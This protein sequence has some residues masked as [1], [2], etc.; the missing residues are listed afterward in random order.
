MMLFSMAQKKKQTVVG[1]TGSLQSSFTGVKMSSLAGNWSRSH[2]S[3]LHGVIL[4]R[5]Q[6]CFFRG[7][8][9]KI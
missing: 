2:C 8:E 4:G 3:P 7:G 5:N 6:K 1:S 9:A